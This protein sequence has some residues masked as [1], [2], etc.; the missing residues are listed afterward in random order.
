MGDLSPEIDAAPFQP[1]VQGLE[2]GKAWHGLPEPMARVLDILLNLS[3]FPAGCWIAE[4]RIEQVVAGHGQEAGIDLAL[5]A[6]TNPVHR[7][8]HVVVD[9]ALRHAAQNPEP[10]VMGVEQHLVR[11]ERIRPDEEGAAVRQLDVR[12]LQLGPLTA[13]DRP[14]LAPVEL[15]SFPARKDQRNER[16]SPTALLL[17]LPVSLPG[18][19]ERRHPV[20]GPLVSQHHQIGVKLFDRSSLLAGF[21]GLRLQPERQ[22]V[23]IPGQL[24]RPIRNSELRLHRARSEVFA[25][26]VPRQS[27]A[28]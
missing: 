16:A 12:N 26:R 24:A 18:P 3:L 27:R 6:A 13:Q 23:R 7:R 28:P 1:R 9:P 8:P 10:M 21:A 20:V 4:V 15:E 5:F 2:I 11:L 19:D 22:L 25:D 14:V 17:P